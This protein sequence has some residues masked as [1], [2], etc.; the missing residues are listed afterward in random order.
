M[1]LTTIKMSH[2]PRPHPRT[3]Y[4][5]HALENSYKSLQNSP[6]PIENVNRDHYSRRGTYPLVFNGQS[7]HT[8]IN[9][10]E[11]NT[12]FKT[13]SQ[14]ICESRKNELMKQYREDWK[15]LTLQEI[16]SKREP[17]IAD[18]TTKRSNSKSKQ[19]L[20]VSISKRN[21]S[22]LS[23]DSRR[24]GDSAVKGGQTLLSSLSNRGRI[25]DKVELQLEENVGR[26]SFLCR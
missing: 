23:K 6:L 21:Q 16:R 9:Q 7:N 5:V 26:N 13:A 15:I 4:E 24:S 2:N 17:K 14:G 20:Y 12:S 18:E 8:L 10:E 19:K 22:S 25:V 1:K 3:S 11:H